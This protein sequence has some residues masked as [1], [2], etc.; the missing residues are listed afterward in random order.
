MLKKRISKDGKKCRVNFELPAE[1][2]AETAT[3]CGEFNDWDKDALPM[4]KLKSGKFT[5]AATLETGKN[6]RFRYWLDGERWENDWEADAYTPNEFG[7]EDSI[8]A[9]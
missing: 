4:K 7:T 6:Y 8:I 9:L 3:L 1:I 2:N 5:A